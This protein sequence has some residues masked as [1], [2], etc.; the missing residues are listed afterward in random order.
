MKVK[1]SVISHEHGAIFWEKKLLG[2]DTPQSLQLAVFWRVGLNFVLCGVEEQHSLQPE[3]FKRFP[4]NVSIYS[5]DTYYEYT[6]FILENNMHRFKDI[7][8]ANK[9]C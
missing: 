5:E 2:Y 3:Q 8:A 9:I 6:E 4:D 7:D 1:A